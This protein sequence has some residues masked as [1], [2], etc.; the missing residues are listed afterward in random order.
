MKFNHRKSQNPARFAATILI[1]TFLFILV[2][3]AAVVRKSYQDNL[4]PVSTSSKTHIVTIAPGATTGE[5]ADLLKAK[6]VIKSDWAFEWYVRNHQLREQL[7]AGTYILDENQSVGDIITIIVD[8]RVATDLVTILPAKRLE[9]IK[10]GFIKAGFAEAEVDAA[11]EPTQWAAHPAL[12]DKPKDA[13]LEGY[14][15]PESFQK[16]ADT[17]AKQIVKLSLD[18]M[19]LRLSPDLRQGISKQGLTLHQGITL[20]SIVEQE[21]SKDADRSQVAQVFLRRYREHIQLQS[22]ATDAYA[23]TDP[24]YDSYKIEGLPP[25][26]I[27]NVSESSLKSI[28]FPAQTDWLYFVSGDDGTTHFSKTLQEHQELT[29]KYCTKLCR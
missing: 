23:K 14:L 27:G 21:V 24:A 17:S 1:G 11:L 3:S 26:P 29:K 2:V 9:E 15:Y 4:K 25:G 13:S 12:T 6:G 19:A 20:A 28:A 16:T 10:A 8:G 7:K 18:E 5:I 22:N